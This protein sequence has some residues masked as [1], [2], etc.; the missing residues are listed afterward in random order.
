M[1]HLAL[2]A[3][4]TVAYL[5]RALQGLRASPE[6]NQI[7]RP[8][9]LWL[10]RGT[11][12]LVALFFGFLLCS[13]QS[14][15]ITTQSGTTLGILAVLL[16]VVLYAI[17]L[18]TRTSIQ[19][20]S[21]VLFSIYFIGSIYASFMWGIEM[22][23]SLLGFALVIM[24]SSILV[25]ARASIVL[26]IIVCVTILVIGFLQVLSITPPDLSWRA[27]PITSNDPI[28][29]AALFFM[30]VLIAWLSNKKKEEL[31]ETTLALKD[32]IQHERDTLEVR[33]HQKTKEIFLLEQDRLMSQQK[34]IEMGKIA[35]SMIHDLSQP[36]TSLGLHLSS[37]EVPQA[38]TPAQTT[39][40]RAQKLS[41]EINRFVCDMRS[42][43]SGSKELKTFVLD[44]LLQNI[45]SHINDTYPKTKAKFI[46][47]CDKE[48]ACTTYPNLLRQALSNIISNALDAVSELPEEYQKIGILCSR[49]DTTTTI[50]IAD[51]GKGIPPELL[52]TIF[53]PFFTSNKPSGTGLGLTIA[54]SLIEHELGGSIRIAHRHERLSKYS[55]ATFI[56]TFPTQHVTD[57]TK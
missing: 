48:Y 43:L 28:Q 37:L 32:D 26:G 39:L 41:T 44:E 11:A 40:A 18:E 23:M 42:S 21:L 12:C 16:T 2:I 8:V 55:G 17:S 36:L 25:S 27:Y 51:S 3:R 57:I 15:G 46:V 10:S 13:V 33:V 49:T 22:P 19:Q 9:F 4:T 30:I 31:L 1:K 56:I 38:D 34:F 35:S 53:T 45:I 54:E 5:R 29:I 24:L 6:A 7:V 50:T 52:E 47:T 20:A 14:N